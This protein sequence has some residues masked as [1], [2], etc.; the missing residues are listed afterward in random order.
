MIPQE[1]IDLPWS[2]R[3]KRGI[4]KEGERPPMYPSSGGGDAAPKAETVTEKPQVAEVTET[5]TVEEAPVSGG[6]T[7]VAADPKLLKEINSR[8]QALETAILSQYSD[9]KYIPEGVHLYEESGIRERHGTI[10]P[11]IWAG[12][13]AITFIG[14]WYLIYHLLIKQ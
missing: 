1:Y 3:K 9:E 4:L 11:W 7:G 5:A 12:Y 6:F 2:V 8:L 10:P 14:A 13:F